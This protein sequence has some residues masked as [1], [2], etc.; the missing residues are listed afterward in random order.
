MVV[1]L[2]SCGAGSALA[3]SDYERGYR[4]GYSRGYQDA[5]KSVNSSLSAR[6]RENKT[7]GLVIIRATYGDY[8]H[9]CDL[10]SWA[11]GYFNNH[12]S[13]TADVTNQLCGD[14]SPGNRKS[15]KVEYYCNGE[16][17]SASAYEH[18]QLSL[19]CY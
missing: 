19:S 6:P 3:D 15:L 16:Q 12:T 1:S 7:R 2:L 8:S 5:Q 17:K 10:T 9:S 13:A 14:P 4:E 18:R 11:A